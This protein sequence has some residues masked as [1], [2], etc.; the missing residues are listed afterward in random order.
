MSQ[1]LKS[2]S[3]GS[4]RVQVFASS[5]ETSL[6][7]ARAAAGLLRETISRTGRARIAV[8]TGNS[9]LQFIAALI[10]EPDIDW[11][12]VEAFH[13]DEYAGMSP[14]H[15]ASFRLWLRKNLAER[16]TLAAMHYLNGDAADVD[17]EC[18]RYG[19]LLSERP[20]DLGF[21]GIGENGH[22]A[23]NDPPVADFADPAA[24]KIVQLDDACRRQQVGEGHF[25]DIASTP[26]RAL[27]LTC[28][29]LFRMKNLICCVPD[30]RKAEAARKTIL[31]PIS[32]S[33][34]ASILRTH[35]SA[36]LFL[37]ADSASLLG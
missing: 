33:C 10:A 16:V 20:V 18:R 21:I 19:A 1:P 3:P 13:L 22:I 34:P 8:S 37:D 32:T 5:S 23:F 27:T 36:Q 25:K 26:E 7:A 31:G 2:F 30:L 15:P 17:E 4:L 9:Q 28:P 11:N 35:S 6:A 29:T 24:V 14:S 12:R